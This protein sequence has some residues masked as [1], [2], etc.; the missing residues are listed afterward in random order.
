MISE[1]AATIRSELGEGPSWDA[2]KGMLYWVDISQ[3]LIYAHSPDDPN[4]EVI[5]RSGKNTSSVVPRKSGGLA[6]TLQ[7]GYYG[8]DLE[9][10]RII[11]LTDP[12]ETDLAENRF[13]DGKC[14]PA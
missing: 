4:D 12:V 2:K 11:S 3:G 8:L 6:L 10:K 7:H 1:I 14:D 9:S 5:A 13:N